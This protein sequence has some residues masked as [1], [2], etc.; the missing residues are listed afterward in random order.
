MR[1]QIHLLSEIALDPV[2]LILL[3]IQPTLKAQD[4]NSNTQLI[5]AQQT[6]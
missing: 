4:I 6:S 1:R 5:L 2:K 3:K